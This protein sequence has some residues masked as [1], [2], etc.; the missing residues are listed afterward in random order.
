MNKTVE[1]MAD[2]Q[3]SL[4]MSLYNRY[5]DNCLYQRATTGRSPKYANALIDEALALCGS[6]YYKVSRR[7]WRAEAIDFLFRFAMQAGKE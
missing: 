3:H 4:A 7:N 2:A 1:W 5:Y 6:P